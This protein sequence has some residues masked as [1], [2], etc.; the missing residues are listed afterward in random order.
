MQETFHEN[1]QNL[2]YLLNSN[3]L[4]KQSTI[5]YVTD[6]KIWDKTSLNPI[7]TRDDTTS[8]QPLAEQFYD[9]YP[10]FLVDFNYVLTPKK[11]KRHLER[12]IPLSLL[13]K[14]DL[15]KEIAVEKCL[16]IASNLTPTLFTEEKWKPLSSRILNEQIKKGN[17]NTFI[18][19]YVLDVLKYSSN[20]SAPVIETKKNLRGDDIYQEGVCSKQF[21]FTSDYSNNGL[22]NYF[23]KDHESINKRRKYA[24]KNLCIATSNPI[25]SNLL[26]LY[27]SI[28]LPSLKEINDEAKRLIALKH[29]TKKGKLLT[30]L[31][32]RTKNYYSSPDT[33]SFVEENIKTLEYLTTRGFM[34]P[35]VGDDKS[36]GRV[37]DSLNLMPSWIRKLIK[38]DGEPIVEI[39]FCAL[40]PN[41]AMNIYGGQKKYITHQQIAKESGIDILK[42]KIDHL[43]FF[44]QNASQMRHSVL[45]DYY[46]NSEKEM[47]NRIVEDKHNSID[48]H[49]ITSKKLFKKE[50]EIMTKC[51]T[52]LNQQGIYVGYVFD[53]LFCKKK[54]A[55]IVWEVMNEEVLNNNVF[56]TAKYE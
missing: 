35:I 16:I 7:D 48:K 28:E 54:E 44:N 29:T 53:A 6:Y 22:A 31:N 20:T 46:Y 3:Q 17:D 18:Y 21:K 37:F 2:N 40:H 36:G 56:T 15:N 38:I 23:L 41:I 19:N 30:F 25:G 34:I 24:Y 55:K 9:T 11:L 1:G 26:H 52:K 42:V 39:D 32:H 5:T 27:E 8:N 33:R 13:K 4:N 50:V 47:I 49:R 14:I 10:Q 43:S 45:Y 51:I 12:E